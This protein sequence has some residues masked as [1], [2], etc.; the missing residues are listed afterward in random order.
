M[1]STTT[2]TVFSII[3]IIMRKFRVRYPTHHSQETVTT[4][5]SKVTESVTG[6][7]HL[8]HRKPNGLRNSMNVETPKESSPRKINPDGAGPCRLIL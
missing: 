3:R 5:A 2:T 4:A 7:R 8:I 6:V 1:Q